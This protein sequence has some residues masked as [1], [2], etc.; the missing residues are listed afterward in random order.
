MVYLA[1]YTSSLVPC[2]NRNVATVVTELPVFNLLN[3]PISRSFFDAK[4]I[5]L[6]SPYSIEYELND[7]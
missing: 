4:N 1:K 5:N 3:D 7:D 2:N 6:L